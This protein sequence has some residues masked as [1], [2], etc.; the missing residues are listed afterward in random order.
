MYGLEIVGKAMTFFMVGFF[1]VLPFGIWKIME[2][3]VW[4]FHHVKVV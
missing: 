1:I 3:V 2:I 4:L